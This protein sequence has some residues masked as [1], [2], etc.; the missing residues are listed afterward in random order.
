MPRMQTCGTRVTSVAFPGWSGS[1]GRIQVGAGGLGC[2]CGHVSA[3]GN[4]WLSQPLP[5]ASSPTSHAPAPPPPGREGSRSRLV[6]LGG[7]V[8][9][10]GLSSEAWSRGGRALGSSVGRAGGVPAVRGA[11][12]HHLPSPLPGPS[13][14]CFHWPRGVQA[15][16]RLQQLLEWTRSAGHGEAGERFFRKLSCALN[17]LATPRAQLIQVGGRRATR[18]GLGAAS[19]LWELAE[20]SRRGPCPVPD[21]TWHRG[22]CTCDSAWGPRDA[23]LTLACPLGAI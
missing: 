14:S 5:A 16:A 9:L 2:R 20:R 8:R 4:L 18:V 10:S 15:S 11:T 3:L 13:L 19:G 6:V 17:L 23:E 12:E 1:V 22:L 21:P 7:H